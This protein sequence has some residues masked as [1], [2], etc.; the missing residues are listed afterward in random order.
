MEQARA[1]GEIRRC[2]HGE[3]APSLKTCHDGSLMVDGLKD[4]MRPLCYACVSLATVLSA[5]P[6]VCLHAH[7][8]PMHV[9]KQWLRPHMPAFVK[10]SAI[11]M[12]PH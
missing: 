5:C 2:L 4:S 7:R 10:N 9:S 3:L 12:K 6:P 11:L 8:L 1:W